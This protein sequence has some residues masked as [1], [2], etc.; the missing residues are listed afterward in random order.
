[1]AHGADEGWQG[2]RPL[3]EYNVGAACGAFWS[4]AKDADGIPDAT[5]SDGTPTGYAVLQVAP[6]GDYTLA[7]HAARAADDVQLLLH[8]PRCCARARMRRGASTP[9]CSWARTTPSLRLRIDNGAWQPMKRV[10]R[11]DPRVLAENVRDDAADALRGYDRSPEATP[12]THLWR[13]ALPTAL[14]VGEHTVEVRATL[15]T[16][17]YSASTVYRLQTA[18]P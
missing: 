15:P 12:S 13:G 7:Y 2:A 3:H 8:A 17:Q 6:S 16:G 10:E 1:M 14:A 5:M 11:A 9:M 4:G 18:M